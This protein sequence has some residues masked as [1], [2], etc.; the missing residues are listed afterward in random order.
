M[1]KKQD[2]INKV[3]DHYQNELKR[4]YVKALSQG[5]K[6]ALND[7][8]EHS[9]D[10]DFDMVEWCNKELKL[11]GNFDEGIDRIYDKKEGKKEE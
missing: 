7:M 10:K 3:T 5:Y 6:L 9:K 11:R 1:S 2:N 8:I 4:N